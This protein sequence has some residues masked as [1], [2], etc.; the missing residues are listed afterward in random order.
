M[1]SLNFSKGAE[2]HEYQVNQTNTP[3]KQSKESSHSKEGYSN[4]YQ[5]QDSRGFR[6]IQDFQEF[7]TIKGIRGL[8][9]LNDKKSTMK[10]LMA[11]FLK[12]IDLEYKNK[13]NLFIPAVLIKNFVSNKRKNGNLDKDDLKKVLKNLKFK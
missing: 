13:Y 4:I 1:S 3:S 7:Q 11:G 10:F 9:G 12:E 6:N 8:K 2:K 5:K